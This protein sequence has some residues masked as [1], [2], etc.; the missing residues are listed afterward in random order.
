MVSTN[1]GYAPTWR[2]DGRELYFYAMDSGVVHM[3]TAS[4]A[5][6]GGTLTV[7]RPQPLF[8]GQ[9]GMTSPIRGYDVSPDGKRFLVVRRVAAPPEAPQQFVLVQNWFAEL[10]RRVK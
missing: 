5:I 1:S 2:A 4:I 9:Y 8:E 7:G 10:N 6:A 3:Q